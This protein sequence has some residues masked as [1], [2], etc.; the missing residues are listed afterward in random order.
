MRTSIRAFHDDL[1]ESITEVYDNGKIDHREHHSDTKFL[2]KIDPSVGLN[3]N[4]KSS[5]FT[6]KLDHLQ[7]YMID[8]MCLVKGYTLSNQAR[9]LYIEQPRSEISQQIVVRET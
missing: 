1:S 4:C 9:H 2:L 6:K 5:R 3:L 7:E 8:A